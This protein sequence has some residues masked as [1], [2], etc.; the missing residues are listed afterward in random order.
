MN[1]QLK[2]SD[3]RCITSNCWPYVGSCF[4][5][6]SCQ[7]S[8][9]N[10]WGWEHQPGFLGHVVDCIKQQRLQMNRLQEPSRMAA[11][12]DRETESR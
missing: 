2:G 11:D 1:K 10:L 3:E 9:T 8:S 12:S 6:R 5:V 7:M 4:V